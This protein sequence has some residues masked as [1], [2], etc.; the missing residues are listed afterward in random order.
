MISFRYALIT[1]SIFLALAIT[2]FN[3]QNHNGY[4]KY[5]NQ[6]KSL[7]RYLNENQTTPNNTSTDITSNQRKEE[8]HKTCIEKKSEVLS[9]SQYYKDLKEIPVSTYQRLSVFFSKDE[10]LTKS[11]INIAEKIVEKESE[12]QS[13]EI[14]TMI[15]DIVAKGIPVIILIFFALLGWFTCCSCCC[16]EYCPIMFRHKNENYSLLYRM[17]P[18]TLVVFSGFSLIIPTILAYIKFKESVN[19][20][21][22][23]LCWDIATSYLLKSYG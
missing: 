13:D 15:I 18:V 19:D 12:N 1:I 5:N 17:V 22:L 2:F 4:N 7:Y 20:L 3:H 23:S 21:K 11:A 16:Y 6:F 9:S 8:Y 14:N 10:N